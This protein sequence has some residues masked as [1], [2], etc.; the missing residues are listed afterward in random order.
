M[1]TIEHIFKSNPELKAEVPEEYGKRTDELIG[2]ALGSEDK[3]DFL[4]KI[5]NHGY[6]KGKDI[7]GI[8][9]DM[10]HLNK[11]NATSEEEIVEDRVYIFT[12][13]SLYLNDLDNKTGYDKEE[14]WK[15]IDV[16]K[17]VVDKLEE[18]KKK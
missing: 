6:F 4:N 7:P 15:Y 11:I 10:I 1:K 3:Y 5:Q 2:I 18:L 16:M 17:R 8:I 14:A 13:S 12:C 9:F